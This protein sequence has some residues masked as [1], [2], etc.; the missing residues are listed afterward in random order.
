MPESVAAVVVTYNRSRLLLECLAA[1]LT[2]SHPLDKIVLI[3]NASTDDTVQALR[4]HGYLN[5]AGIDYSRLS[6]NTG[7]AGGFYEGIRRA[8]E[9][10]VDW[11]WI[12]DD[13][14]EPHPDALERLQIGMRPGIPA[15]ANLTLGND[16]QPQLE[17]RGW[18][19]VCGLTARAHRPIDLASS[20]KQTDISF[21]SFVGL[22]IHRTAITR[23]GL[24]K[25]EL[26]IKGDDLEYCLR[27]SAIGPILLIPESKIRHKDGVSL[28]FEEKRRFGLVS[29]RVPLDKLWLSYFSVRN[30]VWL[31]RQ[32]CGAPIAA[33]YSLHQ[34]LRRAV[35]I[36]VFDS[37]W[38][39]RLRFYYN[40][41]TDAWQDVFDNDKPRR[42]TR[43]PLRSDAGTRDPVI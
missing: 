19:S 15:V 24:P 30:L 20:T 13:D 11:V 37:E 29:Q 16:G 12:M 39:V 9:L 26:F 43:R 17:H 1:L 28:G 21:C 6:S 7:G 23:I 36:L 8:M 5:H 41:I 14:A 22:A 35:G 33:L 40:A 4:A 3:D 2:Q 25:R 27:L 10:G 32:H 34:F 42:L 18:L 31:R 38:V